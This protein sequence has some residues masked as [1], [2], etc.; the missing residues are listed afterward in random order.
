MNGVI[1]PNDAIG[2]KARRGNAS[3]VG[4]S[5]PVISASVCVRECRVRDRVFFHPSS[6]LSHYTLHNDCF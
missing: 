2:G 6:V 5:V 1:R 3:R 4:S